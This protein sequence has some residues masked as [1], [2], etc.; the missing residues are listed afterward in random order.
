M[1]IPSKKPVEPA[2]E[3]LERSD[4]EALLQIA[5]AATSHLD[6]EELLRVVVSKVAEVV[7]VDRCSALL[8]EDGIEQAIVIASHDV[9]DLR[10][11]PIDIDRYPEIRKALESKAHVVVEDALTD[12]LM[13]QVRQYLVE[14]PVASLVVAPLVAQGDAV[15]ALFLRLARS[16]AF[17]PHEQAFVRAVASTVANSVRNARLH[18][19]V[20]KRRDELQA[21]YQERYEELQ[22][23]NE[24]LREANRIKDELLAVCSH[25]LRAP[26]NVL[27][28]HTRLLQRRMEQTPQHKSVTV[29]ERQARRILQL[30]E[31]ILIRS[32]GKH[33]WALAVEPLDLAPC[34]REIAADFAAL[35]EE[36]GVTI[37]VVGEAA[38]QV[39]ADESAIRQILEN[40]ISNAVAYTHPQT[41]VEVEVVPSA[42][43]AAW[44]RV[45]VR[46]RGPGVSPDELPLV[47]ERY[48]Q[49]D[50]GEGVGLGLA[51]CKELVELHGGEISVALR[52]G[53]GAV[54]SFTLPT[55]PC[56]TT[57][58][59]ALL[60]VAEAG[61]RRDSLGARLGERFS[62][63]YAGTGS[64]GVAQAARVLPDVVVVDA[65]MGADARRFAEE[66]RRQPGLGE[67]PTI[68]F[69][70]APEGTPAFAR[71]ISCL[72]ELHAVLADLP[73]GT[74]AARLAPERFAP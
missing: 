42:H 55:G 59:H 6:L 9:P 41:T 34:V 39:Q 45:E 46:D 7:Q 40:L 21:A 32:K 63:S 1:S 71:G 58:S 28:G 67:V 36:K 57:R 18:S 27:L 47:F 37:Q 10:R 22:R 72:E 26:L 49:G 74:P 64:E 66:I 60:V 25:D 12:P 4:L 53:G 30:V 38:A 68:F 56:P 16:T 15:G 20:R 73:G 5:E 35:A 52:Q 51:I 65:A 33:A 13:S 24:Q 70:G 44:C 23:L 3:S 69:G 14:K 19:S 48:R 54:F 11:L 8:V 31:R 61:E 17:G 62:I 2:L 50:A 43:S 29:I